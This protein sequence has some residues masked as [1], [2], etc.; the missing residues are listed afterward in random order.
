MRQKETYTVLSSH[1][2]AAVGDGGGG[3]VSGV[4]DVVV[5][6]ARAV[7]RQR[8]PP[9]SDPHRSVLRSWERRPA[10]SRQGQQQAAANRPKPVPRHRLM[11]VE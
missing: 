2:A 3:H 1:V 9:A 10:G 4:V 5:V 11:T 7:V 8:L 6:E